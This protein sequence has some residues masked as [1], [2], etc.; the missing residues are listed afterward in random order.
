MSNVGCAVVHP[1][2]P[3]PLPILGEGQLVMDMMAPEGNYGGSGLENN[4][5]VLRYTIET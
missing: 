2:P 5:D 4:R 1:S 3:S